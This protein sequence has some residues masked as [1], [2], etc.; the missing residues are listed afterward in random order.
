MKHQYRPL[1]LLC[2]M[3]LTVGAM[4]T[5]NDILLP[6]VIDYF[7]LSYTQATLIQVSFYITYIIFPIP[8]AWMIHKYGYRI[9]LLVALVTSALGC[10]M[11]MPAQFSDSYVIILVAIFILSTGITIINVA[12]NPFT[13][14]LG[15]PEGAHIRINFV[16]S[17][18]RIGYAATPVVAAVLIYSSTGEIRF[19]FPY[20]LIGIVI[21]VIAALIYF[22]KMPGMHAPKEDIFSFSGVIRKSRQYP[23]LLFGVIAMFFYVGAE[24][25]TAGFFIP[26]LTSELGFTMT[27]AVEYLT[28]YYIFA[29]AMGLVVAL[30]V[31]KYISAHKLVGIFGTAMI[32]AYLICIFMNTGYNAYVLASLGLG[33]SIMFPT[34]FSLAI[35]DTGDFAGSGSALLN[36]A[37]VGGA[38]FTP[39]QGILADNF[40]VAISY[41]I[42]CFCFIVIT[43]YA[44]FFTKKP[45]EERKARLKNKAALAAK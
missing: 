18:S 36:F 14:L 28:L 29:A 23:H 19:Y 35:E 1:I 9:S 5:M 2:L 39:V 42:P 7:K 22:S 24:A 15:D 33:L 40:G 21:L 3:F 12:A 32:V 8:I 16:Q 20:M 4:F 17:F 27:E 11:F 43:L 37:I 44:L 6:T 26:Y 34:L 45:L 38:V 13:T 41:V 25:S 30:W 31:L 10:L